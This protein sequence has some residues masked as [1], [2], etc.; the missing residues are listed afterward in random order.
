MES[1]SL[2][3]RL[4]GADGI[5]RIVDDGVA[6]HLNNPRINARFKPHAEDPVHFAELKQH[7]CR[8]LAM[9]S[10]GPQEYTGRSMLDAHKGMNISDSEYLAAVDDFMT[11]LARHNIDES[12]RKDVLYMCYILRGEIVGK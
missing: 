5:A 10:G 7:L 3:D 8:F 4:G 12:S 11:T 1:K 2:Y 6:A 9:G